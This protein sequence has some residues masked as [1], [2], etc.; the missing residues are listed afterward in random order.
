MLELAQN[1]EAIHH[2]HHQVQQYKVG[3]FRL[4]FAI[5]IQSVLGFDHVV[6]GLVQNRGYDVSDI[7]FIINHENLGH[8]CDIS[9]RKLPVTSYLPYYFSD[10]EY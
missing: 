2:R 4:G 3:L 9:P 8:S 7:S 6:A 10:T 1:L 5:P